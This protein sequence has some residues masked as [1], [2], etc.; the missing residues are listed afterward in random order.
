MEWLRDTSIFH[1]GDFP[2]WM[3]YIIGPL[4]S[5][6]WPIWELEG[7][8]PNCQTLR[9][10]FWF[11]SWHLGAQRMVFVVGLGFGG[12]D[13]LGSMDKQNRWLIVDS[14]RKNTISKHLWD[15]A[16]SHEV[17]QY[18]TLKGWRVQISDLLKEEIYPRNRQ[19]NT[20]GPTFNKKKS[21]FLFDKMASSMFLIYWR[22]LWHQKKYALKSRG[23][24]II[25][26]R[27]VILPGTW[28]KPPRHLEDRYKLLGIKHFATRI[29]G[30]KHWKGMEFFQCFFS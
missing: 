30:G 24:K 4:S 18:P 15:G 14:W 21:R 8:P 25:V 1:P 26:G 28:K 27:D 17:L 5:P 6:K 3:G 23:S 2:G 13:F 16:T 7:F 22:W 29:L 10:F 12:L 9:F 19:K 11:F 20:L